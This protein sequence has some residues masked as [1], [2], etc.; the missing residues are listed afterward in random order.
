MGQSDSLRVPPK[1]PSAALKSFQL[2]PDFKIELVASEPLI[3][4]PVAVAFRSRR[5]DVR[6][7]SFP[8]SITTASLQVVRPKGAVKLLRDT[9]G[10]GRFDEAL[11]FLKEI[12]FPTAVACYD[13]RRVRGSRPELAVLQR[14][15]R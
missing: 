3:R 11:P 10:D 8:S 7:P 9:N 6:G 2:H 14:H 4:D 13:R 1:S 15:R 12:S 5:P